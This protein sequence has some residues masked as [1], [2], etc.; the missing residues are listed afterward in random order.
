MISWLGWVANSPRG[1]VRINMATARLVSV[2]D[3]GRTDGQTGIEYYVEKARLLSLCH[4]QMEKS[5]GGVGDGKAR[6]HFTNL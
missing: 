6:Q 5:A 1:G 2:R 4:D 3:D